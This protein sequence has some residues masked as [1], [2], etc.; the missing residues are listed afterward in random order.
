MSVLAAGMHFI[1]VEFLGVR[2]V[3]ASVVIDGDGGIA[4]VDPGPST[5]LEALRGGLRGLGFGVA[6]IRTILLTHIH[7]DH[8]GATGTLVQEH[9]G[10]QVYVHERGARH[11]IDP[12]RLLESATR[13]YGADGMVRLWGDVLPVPATNVRALGGGEVIEVCG[14]GVDVAYTPGHASH[15]VS[16]LDRQTRIAF[17]G[18][19][20]GGRLG[21][22]TFVMTPTP[23]P[24]IDLAAWQASIETILAWEPATLFLTHFGPSPLEP[25][26]HLAELSERLPRVAAF[27]REAMQQ[28]DTDEA[29]MELF[30]GEMRRELRR[31]MSEPDARGY[32]LAMPFDHC[33]YGLQRY[34]QKQG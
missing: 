14:R 25:S 6:D 32:E 16:Y 12:T 1:D 15:H 13:L 24:D 30:R 8:A 19:V 11:V 7:L 5:S 18:D 29:R 4:I 17:V 23:P 10:I 31:H 2:Q 20:A 28:G 21:D 27:A 34:W 3:I 22:S 33:F 26:V 9:P